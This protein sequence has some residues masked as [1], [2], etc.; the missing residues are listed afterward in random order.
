MQEFQLHHHRPVVGRNRIID[1]PVTGT[2]ESIFRI[3]GDVIEPPK[4]QPDLN[5]HNPRVL[6]EVKSILRFWLDRGV[7]GF[8][9]DVI[10]VIYKD[11]LADGKPGS[12]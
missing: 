2:A 11:T 7:V 1:H 10:N 3:S 12:P 8:R 9:C 4:K 6:E 5:W